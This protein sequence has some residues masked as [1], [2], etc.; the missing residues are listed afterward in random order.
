MDL[1]PT[2]AITGH[3]TTGEAILASTK[4][5]GRLHR[6]GVLGRHGNRMRNWCCACRDADNGYHVLYTPDDTPW[7][8]DNGSILKLVGKSRR[9]RSRS[10]PVKRP[11][12]PH[13]AKITVQARGSRLEVFFKRRSV[14]IRTNDPTFASGSSG[15]GFT[16]DPVKTL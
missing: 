8:A 12:L 13:S 4:P 1:G 11:G 5:Y 7:A 16:G 2:D 14:S 6:V 10:W 3:S 9:A 15:C